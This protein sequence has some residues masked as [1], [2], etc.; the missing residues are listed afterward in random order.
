MGNLHERQY[1]TNRPYTT[2]NGTAACRCNVMTFRRL[3]STNFAKF[4]ADETE[5]WAKVIRTANIK[6]D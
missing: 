2:D 6:P 3:I 4:I 5:K 1:D